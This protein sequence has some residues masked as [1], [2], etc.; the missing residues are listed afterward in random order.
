[1]VSILKDHLRIRTRPARW[2][3]RLHR[4][5]TQTCDIS[6]VVLLNSNSD[7]CTCGRKCGR[8][9]D[10]PHTPEAKQR[11]LCQLITWVKQRFEEKLTAF[12]RKKVLYPQD[13]ARFCV[14]HMA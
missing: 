9:L 11:M 14:V 6:E 7:E 2:V 12:A 3:P 4:P 13:N 1:M 8:N 5:Q 10:L